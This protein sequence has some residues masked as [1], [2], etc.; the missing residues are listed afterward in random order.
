MKIGQE[1][2]GRR[3]AIF[4]PDELND[5]I[6]DSLPSGMSVDYITCVFG[7]IEELLGQIYTRL[8]QVRVRIAED[9]EP[10]PDTETTAI[11]ALR[12]FQIAE[13]ERK[14][15]GETDRYRHFMSQGWSLAAEAIALADSH[16][17]ELVQQ[18]IDKH[19]HPKGSE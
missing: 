10:K 3:W 8:P 6:M 18:D 1:L 4:S 7:D 17:L 12:F 16:K 2:D 19:L 14:Q 15:K 11:Q 5:L 13:L 9:E